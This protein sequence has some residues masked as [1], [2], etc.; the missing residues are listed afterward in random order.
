MSSSA[1]CPG[2]LTNTQT[3]SVGNSV[4]KLRHP[5]SADYSA[6]QVLLNKQHIWCGRAY[7]DSYQSIFH[8]RTCVTRWFHFPITMAPMDLHFAVTAVEWS[9]Q[10]QRQNIVHHVFGKVST[11]NSGHT[12]V[13]WPIRTSLRT[14]QSGNWFTCKS[15]THA[16]LSSGLKSGPAR[17][18]WVRVS[19]SM[20]MVSSGCHWPGL[21]C[22]PGWIL[23]WTQV[24]EFTKS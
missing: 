21:V 12:L 9:I 11:T 4:D 22:G 18:V 5:R 13:Q 20:V 8:V 14:A 10:F 1:N 2:T 15:A 24:T 6:A 16:G 17:D 3:K 19:V 7:V 23:G